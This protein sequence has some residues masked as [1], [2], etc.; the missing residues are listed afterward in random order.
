VVLLSIPVTFHLKV[1][2][3]NK[4][5]S[6]LLF[7]ETSK[8]HYSRDNEEKAIIISNVNAIDKIL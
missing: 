7:V 2:S 6:I 1:L 3:Q 8:S 5:P 4:E